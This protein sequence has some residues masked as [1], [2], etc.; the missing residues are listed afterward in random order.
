MSI[1]GVPEHELRHSL[2][3]ISPP[4]RQNRLNLRRLRPHYDY[5]QSV[6][7]QLQDYSS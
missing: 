5:E 3:R 1:S 7:M 2:A 6:S 4:S